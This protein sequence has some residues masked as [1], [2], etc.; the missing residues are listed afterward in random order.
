MMRKIDYPTDLLKFKEDYYNLLVKT[1][2]RQIN[3]FL[4]G[5]PL[6]FPRI[7]FKDLVTE[8]FENLS[9]WYYLLENYFKSK[10]Q[11]E[12]EIFKNLFEYSLNQPF[13]ADFFMNKRDELE[14]KTCFY[15]NIDFINSFNDIGE[16]ADMVDF[17]N[18]ATLK[19]LQIIPGL[20]KK[21][22]KIFK[23]LK[24]KNILNLDELLTINGVGKPL[25]NKIKSIKL[26]DL[27]KSRNQFTLDHFIPQSKC[28]YFSLSVFNL[29]PSCYSCNSKFKGKIIFEDFENLKFL[30][31]SSDLFSLSSEIGFKIYFNSKGTGLNEKIRNTKI[32]SDIRVDFE[33]IGN[34]KEFDTYL[35]MFKL[36]GRYVYHKNEALKLVKKRK[37]YPDTEIDDIAR[38]TGRTSLDI[39]NDIFG[40]VIFK[41]DEKNEPFAKYKREV[42]EQLGLRP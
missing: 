4:S 22:H 13:I 17:F 27:K 41:D 37:D 19:E 20:D 16:Y 3:H 32:L 14:I 11:T 28:P 38:I 1:N 35:D 39:K 5:I 34:V 12:V 31:P 40:S 10:T 18:K 21:A 26:S 24:S 36:K 33:N 9:G 8:G 15:C 30:S 23:E 2:E 29:I 25:V 7:T 6:I 42:A